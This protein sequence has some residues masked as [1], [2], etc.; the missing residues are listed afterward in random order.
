MIIIFIALKSLR[1]QLSYKLILWVSVS[2]LIFAVG[3]CMGAP[4]GDTPA[5]TIQGILIQFGTM[6][7]VFW[8]VAISWTIDYL[9]NMSSGKLPTKGKL[10]KILYI[11]HIII[12]SLTT[13]TT[14]VPLFTNTYGPA[15]GWCWFKDEKDI[16]NIERYALFYGL[17]WLSIAYM[18][19]IYIKTWIKIRRINNQRKHSTTNDKE[20]GLN[21]KS[22]DI[23]GS[24]TGD[25][26]LS[27]T[28]SASVGGLSVGG[29]ELKSTGTQSTQSVLSSS[30]TESHLKPPETES[31]TDRCEKR[32]LEKEKQ[33]KRSKALNRMF[34]FPMVLILGY[35]F[36]SIRRIYDLTHG[37]APYWVAVLQISMNSLLG[38]FDALVYGM[39]KDVREKDKELLIKLC[40][41]TDEDDDE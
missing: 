6:S 22:Q 41:C 33:K 29:T 17:V 34:M 14:I 18:I 19:Y 15:G 38:F 37:Q 10:R 26:E 11:M 7:S 28:A 21:S 39:T 8:V 4:S 5:C 13:I 36:G 1:T 20:K 23:S 2:D 31:L 35:L 12:W 3:N 24:G 27:P 9:M 16:D 40:G 30:D 25:M 32:K